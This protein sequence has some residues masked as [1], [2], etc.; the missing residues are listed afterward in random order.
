MVRS[1]PSLALALL[2]LR[3]AAE[4]STCEEQAE[5]AVPQKRMFELRNGHATEALHWRW[6]PAGIDSP[7]DADGVV[8][9]RHSVELNSFVGHRFGVLGAC[10]A[11]FSVTASLE[12]VAACAEPASGAPLTFVPSEAADGAAVGS[13]PLIRPPKP[14]RPAEKTESPAEKVQRGTLLT[15][16]ADTSVDVYWIHP[17]TKEEVPMGTIDAG[18]NRNFNSY[19]G[20]VF[21][22]K[23]ACEMDV[24]VE[25]DEV[26]DRN[27]DTR[28]ITA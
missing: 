25:E 15:N 20:H 23:G 22:V 5:P 17:T 3:C 28:V 14:A 13:T 21:R 6:I 10:S 16:E 26:S 18:S 11:A 2:L 12:I 27:P 9:P 4:D 1:P 8:P 7:G 19:R 24:T